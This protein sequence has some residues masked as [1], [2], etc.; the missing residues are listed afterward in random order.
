MGYLHVSFLSNVC[1][2]STVTA[3]EELENSNQIMS[4]RAPGQRV[5]I[6]VAKTVA[7][8]G[9]C[10]RLPLLVL[11]CVR[12]EGAGPTTVSGMGWGVLFG[13]GRLVSYCM[14]GS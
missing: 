5:L 9:L 4:P 8:G 13:H 7:R 2:S 10:V 6:Q 3:Y 12:I 14:F 1:V 11:F